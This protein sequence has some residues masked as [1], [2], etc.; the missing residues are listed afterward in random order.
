M[1]RLKIFLLVVFSA[2]ILTSFQPQPQTYVYICT[3]AKS[4]RYHKINTCSGLKSCSKEIIKITKAEAINKYNRT[5]CKICY[6]YH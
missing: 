6:K 1:K 2:L 3:G 5:P 4:E